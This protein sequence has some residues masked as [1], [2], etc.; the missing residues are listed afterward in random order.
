MLLKN[1][2]NDLRLPYLMGIA[3]PSTGPPDPIWGCASRGCACRDTHK[4]LIDLRRC[5]R[6]LRM[7]LF[8]ERGQ[9][10]RIAAYAELLLFIT[11]K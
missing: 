7:T 8:W 11:A 9:P 10:A 1:I 3:F 4:V 2:Q 6:V 5:L